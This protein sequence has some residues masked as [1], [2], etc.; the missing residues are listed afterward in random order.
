MN[1]YEIV[2]EMSKICE[3]LK[4]K[5]KN[6]KVGPGEAEGSNLANENVILRN[7][8]GKYLFDFSSS[9]LNFKIETQ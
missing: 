5:K 2:F 1:N 3:K 9:R 4:K 7:V 8:K 6:V